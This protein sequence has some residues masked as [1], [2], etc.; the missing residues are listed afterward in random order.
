M[1][2]LESSGKP[3]FFRFRTPAPGALEPPSNSEFVV[4]RTVACS[5]AGMQKEALISVSGSP[6][7]WRLASD[8]GAYLNGDNV[9]PC[10][11]SFLT[12]GMA[13][14]FLDSILTL[15][16]RR[17]IEISKL[18]LILDNYYTMKGSA[19]A[20]TMVGGALPVELTAETASPAGEESIQHL[21]R[22][23][24]AL[25]PIHGLIRDAL[26]SVFTLSLNGREIPTGR[27][28]RLDQRAGSYP[29]GEFEQ[30]QPD[31]GEWSQLLTRDGM[32]PKTEEVTSATGS[33]YAEHQ[34]RTLHV[35]GICSLRPD[36][37]KAI[38]QQL[39]NPHGSIFHFL[40]DEGPA[41]RAPSALAYASA[42]IAFC[43][44]TQF[45]RYAKI[46]R[47]NLESYNVVQDTLFQP[48]TA[49]L[50]GRAR[51]VETH[52]H[53]ES[54]ENEDFARMSLDMSE[55]TCFLHA[56]CRTN[57]KV[58]VRVKGIE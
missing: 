25:S 28:D 55:Q 50:P 31:P 34:N 39:F 54:P 49:E 33:S 27:V 21:I 14:S 6:A 40:S 11:L 37:M 5:L 22:E 16:R 47:K 19:L 43:F 3:L 57:L 12:T 35:R 51:P 10:P 45:G 13:A 46:A 52:V 30:A 8:E 48:G 17:Q 18:R 36:G 44:L 20:G 56:L 58:N 23:A 32:S 42:G 2:P 7:R 4:V 24:V 15:S 38:E 41:A 1:T 53:L 9:A 26:P 29:A